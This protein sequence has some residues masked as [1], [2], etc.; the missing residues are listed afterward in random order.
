MNLLS[1]PVNGAF[2]V[3]LQSITAQNTNLQ[4]QIDDFQTYIDARQ[5]YLTNQYNQADIA[6]QQIPLLQ[7]Q[8]NAELG[9][10]TKTS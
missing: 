9:I 1:D 7:A 6:L 3:D 8:L 4:N 5:T 2:T 10:T